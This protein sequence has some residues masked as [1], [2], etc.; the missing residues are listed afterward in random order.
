MKKV[1]ATLGL[2]L[3]LLMANSLGECLVNHTNKQDKVLLVKWIVGSYAH[4]PALKGVVSV[5]E[6]QFQQSEK[7]VATLF[8]R[9]LTKDCA[10][11]FK[12]AVQSKGESAVAEAFGYLGRVAGVE[13]SANSYVKKY[14]GGFVR[15]IK[16]SFF[17]KL[18][19]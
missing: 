4:H 5:N 9:L 17:A 15:Y 2:G 12:A 6:Q 8:E 3:S 14:L 11:E 7:K 16:P 10:N 18:E 19:Q 13:V 1:V